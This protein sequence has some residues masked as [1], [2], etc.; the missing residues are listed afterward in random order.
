MRVK[1]DVME[2]VEKLEFGVYLNKTPVQIL[3]STTHV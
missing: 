2:R 3:A 1:I